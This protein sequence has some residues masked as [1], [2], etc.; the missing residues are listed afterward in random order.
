M[1]VLEKQDVILAINRSHEHFDH[2]GAFK[3]GRHTRVGGASDEQAPSLSPTQV[4][5]DCVMLLM[6]TQVL[7]PRKAHLESIRALC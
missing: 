5:A 7:R 6:Y 4:E 2:K 3:L 1:K